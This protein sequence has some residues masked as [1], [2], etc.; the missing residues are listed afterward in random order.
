MTEQFLEYLELQK[1]PDMVTK[2]DLI[3]Q[4]RHRGGRISDRLLSYYA[5]EVLIPNAARVGSRRGVLRRDGAWAGY[6]G[7]SGRRGER[8]G[9]HSV[10]G[11]NSGH[12]PPRRRR[13][14]E[15]LQHDRSPAAYRGERGP[16][17]RQ[18]GR[19]YA[20]RWGGGVR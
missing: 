7:V 3:E 14:P 12:V 10:Q 5:S 13:S 9:G 6:G 17:C 4:V 8:R 15:R 1:E 2:S 11:V 18:S 20:S 19:R 16:D